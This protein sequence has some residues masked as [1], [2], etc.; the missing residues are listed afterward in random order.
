MTEGHSFLTEQQIAQELAQD[1]TILKFIL[2]RFSDRLSAEI[3]ENRKVYDRKLLPLFIFINERLNS[4]MTPTEIDNA[5]DGRFSDNFSP[6]PPPSVNTAGTGYM[7]ELFRQ[8]SQ[9][10]EKLAKAQEKRTEVEERKA[11]AMEKRAEAEKQK[12]DAMNH[13]ARA[14][15]EMKDQARG[16]EKRAE[17][18][19]KTAA[20]VTSFEESQEPDDLL[21]LIDEIP[22][23]T[24][25]KR[26]APGERPELDD[27]SVLAEALEMEEAKGSSL[28]EDDV[29]DL[30]ELLDDEP[31]QTEL[32]DKADLDDLSMLIDPSGD[33]APPTDDLRLLIEESEESS[34]GNRDM[35]LDDL[36]L[37]VQDETETDGSTGGPSVETE[38]DDLSRLIETEDET[39]NKEKADMLDDLSLLIED[40]EPSSLVPDISPDEDFEAYKQAI[41]NI[42]I[43]LKQ[44]GLTP[45]D[46]CE[47]FNK[48]GVKTLSGKSR[49]SVKT[50]NGIYRFIDSAA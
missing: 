16:G 22:E 14:L 8:F 6:S 4:G 41:I 50:I 10:R 31:P 45:E 7:E 28:D 27:L 24:E 37:L 26:G 18:A 36:S 40:Q 44:Q 39:E 3:H 23:E 12:A 17:L 29:N 15:Q 49:W 33:T 20:A 19:E 9:D 43:E 25:E 42:I 35:E 21:S 11:A 47:R 5:I 46:T 1:R 30:A 13:I 38:T 32:P 2:N 48:E 34:A